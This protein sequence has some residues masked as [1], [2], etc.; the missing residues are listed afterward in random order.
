[1]PPDLVKSD[2]ERTSGH[3]REAQGAYRLR[4]S[5]LQDHQLHSDID[6]IYWGSAAEESDLERHAMECRFMNT[7]IEYNG[8]EDVRMSKFILKLN[9]ERI[10]RFQR[11]IIIGY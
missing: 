6:A 2:S 11:P 1:M 9:R 4:R 8:S 5:A 10:K 7:K 3:R